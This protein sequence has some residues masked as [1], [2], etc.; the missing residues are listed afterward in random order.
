MVER[1][2]GQLELQ[3]NIFDD[4]KI[5]AVAKVNESIRKK[6]VE[7]EE[8]HQKGTSYFLLIPKGYRIID[9]IEK[10]INMKGRS[11][12]KK[13]VNILQLVEMLLKMA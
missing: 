3:S 9:L 7:F 10:K 11:P 4:V 2:K 12:E 5:G 8:A 1:S 13:R 6:L